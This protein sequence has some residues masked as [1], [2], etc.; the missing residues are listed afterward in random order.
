MREI[1]CETGRGIWIEDVLP[2]VE[3][4]RLLETSLL[5]R[6]LAEDPPLVDLGGEHWVACHLRASR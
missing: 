4:W 1:D 3:S 6:C 2:G 5:G